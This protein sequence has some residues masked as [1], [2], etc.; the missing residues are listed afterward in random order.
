MKRIVILLVC[1]VGGLLT[2]NTACASSSQTSPRVD[3][4][5]TEHAKVRTLLDSVKGFSLPRQIIAVDEFLS[6]VEERPDCY[7]NDLWPFEEKGINLVS[8]DANGVEI[9]PE[10]LFYCDELR[11]VHHCPPH[12]EETPLGEVHVY[13][14][15]IPLAVKTLRVVSKWDD[16]TLVGIYDF[17]GRKIRQKNGEFKRPLDGTRVIAIYRIPAPMKYRKY[18]WLIHS[19]EMKPWGQ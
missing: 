19:K 12:D 8:I 5:A 2:T 1:C 18:E 3:E 4:C 13:A 7:E 15:P 9:K 17:H 6:R 10:F 16:A 14:A 11:V